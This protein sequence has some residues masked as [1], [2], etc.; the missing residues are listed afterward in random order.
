SLRRR[1]E[2]QLQIKGASRRCQHTIA[3][4][5]PE[6]SAVIEIDHLEERRFKHG[7][8][9]YGK[10]VYPDNVMT[11]IRECFERQIGAV[12]PHARILYIV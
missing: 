3:S 12:L 9:G 7:Q 6:G 5:R 10:Y 2:R 11:E 4:A 8:F 1:G